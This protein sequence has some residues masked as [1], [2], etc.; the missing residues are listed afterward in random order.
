MGLGLVLNLDMKR[1][2]PTASLAKRGTDERV[3]ER[4]PGHR[5]DASH[6]FSRQVPK[7][8][9]FGRIGRSGQLGLYPFE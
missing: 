6:P 1:V 7:E 4:L 3:D 5:G 9:V 8:Q 2:G